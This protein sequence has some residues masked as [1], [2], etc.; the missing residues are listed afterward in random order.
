MN[1][2][3][4][5]NR[6]M[7][8]MIDPVRLVRRLARPAGVAAAALAVLAAAVLASVPEAVQAQATTP[9]ATSPQ[10]RH[11]WHVF[12]AYAV[13]WILLFGWVVAIFRRLRRVEERLEE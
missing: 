3:R 6:S 8:V 2:N 9:A 11:F 5:L 4:S 12:A 13:A 7:K 10:M 1:M